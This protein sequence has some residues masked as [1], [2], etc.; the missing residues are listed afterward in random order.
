MNGSARQ[1]LEDTRDIMCCPRCEGEIL[2]RDN[3]I[4]C[5]KCGQKYPIERQIP[6][7]FWPNEWSR[8]K[9]DVTEAVRAFYENR[10]FPNYDDCDSTG[11]LIE[12]AKRSGFVS[13]LDDQIPFGV[14]ILEVGCGTG[15]LTN[16]LGIS[17]RTVFGTDICL[18]SLALGQQFKEKNEILGSHFIQMNLFRPAFRP[19]SFHL[20]FCSGVL[21]HT[22]DPLGGFRSISRLIRP[23]GYI[24]IGLYHRF[25]RMMHSVRRWV[26][27][28]FGDRVVF[29][30][31]R[32][33]R[34][35]NL[36]NAQKEAW[37]ADQYKHPHE[38][39]H[40]I[41]EITGWFDDIGFRFVKSIP[42]A[43]LFAGLRV[44]E[45]L[46]QAEAPGTWWERKLVEYG[47]IFTGGKEGGYFI[48]IGQ[49]KGGV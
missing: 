15:Q 21:H 5:S 19:Q 9:N 17:N 40:T 34:G 8:E 18:N 7:M 36:G 3:S 1:W 16:F 14:R 13:L 33:R 45:R 20:V 23:N 38:S 27:N 44:D 26:I 25:G 29:L 11:S 49:R 37:F 31:P 4:E 24:V 12:K 2:I 28:R 39:K 6:L 42:K 32:F 48:V 46:F 10:P 43:G 35:D 41:N 22:S 47:M 30:D